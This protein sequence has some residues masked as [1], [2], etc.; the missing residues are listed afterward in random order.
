[1]YQATVLGMER[2]VRTKWSKDFTTNLL[3]IV[4][5]QKMCVNVCCCLKIPGGD[6]RSMTQRIQT[7][8][9]YPE[10]GDVRSREYYLQY[11]FLYISLHSPPFVYA[12]RRGRWLTGVS[13]TRM[14][15]P[16]ETHQSHLSTP[17]TKYRI[18]S[19]NRISW[20]WLSSE[21][22]GHWTG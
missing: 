15:M 18:A 1:V 21:I 20:L 22:I 9:A 8:S 11:Y 7:T 12:V 4:S 6:G 19:R 17:L 16:Q 3:A 10:V 13:V 14:K 2:T 5:D